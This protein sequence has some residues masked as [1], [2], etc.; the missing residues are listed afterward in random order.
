MDLYVVRR[1]LRCLTSAPPRA[2]FSAH[3]NNLQASISVQAMATPPSHSP[4]ALLRA[5]APIDKFVDAF[6]SSLDDNDSCTSWAQPDIGQTQLATLVAKVTTPPFVPTRRYLR[7]LLTRYASKVE[8][9]AGGQIEDEVLAELFAEHA[10]GPSSSISP[11]PAGGPATGGGMGGGDA[12]DPDANGYVSFQLPQDGNGSTYTSSPPDENIVGIRVYPH[13][14]DV[15]IR[16]VWEA[17]ACLAEFLISN[18]A[19][20]R[21]K[22]VLEL[23]AGVG[24]TGIVAAGLC[25]AKHL[26]MTDYTE[27]CLDNMEHNIT[28]NKDWLVRQGVNVDDNE[29]E[30]SRKLTSGYLEWTECAEGDN[31]INGRREVSTGKPFQISEAEV[32]LAADVVYDASQIPSLVQSVKLLLSSGGGSGAT[33]DATKKRKAIFATTFRNEKTFALFTNE[34]LNEGISCKYVE[35]EVIAS[36][37]NIFPCYFTQ[38]RSDVRICTMTL[39]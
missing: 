25:Q 22:K 16:K 30:C 20:I 15:G 7:L 5:M 33:R 38:P 21:D 3:H 27:A 32:L 31:D 39:G 12:P 36:L 26:H 34:L 37:P 29:Y 11:S 4:E 1:R 19:L 9:E 6:T 10:F 18:P 35:K 8:R 14:N 2:R 24:L 17:G 28:V 13:H 23:G